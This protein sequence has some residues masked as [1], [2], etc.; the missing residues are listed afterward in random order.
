MNYRQVLLTLIV[1]TLCVGP[2]AAFDDTPNGEVGEF[3]S[4]TANGEIQAIAEDNGTVYVVGGDGNGD[5]IMRSHN[6]SGDVTL[7]S[8]S[9]LPATDVVVMDGVAYVSDKQG[10]LHIIDSG[11]VNSTNIA[12]NQIT[13]LATGGQY[14]Y[15]ITE[16]H[17]IQKIN[18]SGGVSEE[19][20]ASQ[21]WEPRS[22]SYTDNGLLVA[23]SNG[24][25]FHNLTT[26]V[27]SYEWTESGTTVN[28][29]Y[30]E[31]GNAYLVAQSGEL[32]EVDVSANTNT[33]VY[34]GSNSLGSIAVDGDHWYVT[35]GDGNVTI[36]NSSY[37]EEDSIDITSDEIQGLATANRSVVIGN[38]DSYAT[39]QRYGHIGY[40]VPINVTDTDNESV[41]NVTISDGVPYTSKKNV[42]DG[43]TL[44][45]PPETQNMTAKKDGYL[46]SSKNVTITSS[47]RTNGV[48]ITLESGGEISGKVYG[49]DVDGPLQ[50][51]TVTVDG[52]TRTVDGNFSFTVTDGEYYVNVD[53]PGYIPKNETV[54]I[55]GNNWSQ[56]ITLET[57]YVVSGVVENQAGNPVPS[58]VIESPVTTVSTDESGSFSIPVKEGKS[59]LSV[60]ADGYVTRSYV[61]ENVTSDRSGVNITVVSEVGGGGSTQNFSTIPLFGTQIPLPLIQFGAVFL[62]LSAL[63]VG[64]FLYYREPDEEFH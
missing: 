54:T 36:L 8:S 38:T 28:D 22:L 21:T 49:Q 63:A 24:Y 53:K 14:V 10:T 23:G 26:N 46:Q 42:S 50:N 61:V 48:S 3:W 57:G 62:L 13:G 30:A 47:S 17:K 43:E 11:S 2:V 51:V 58:A 5:G 16:Q 25:G 29:T 60:S 31:N 33:T 37:L 4:S 55:S 27:D 6:L 35:T 40:K 32:I 19:W 59:N 44:L 34:T 64:A 7:V 52:T 45:L 15:A 12:S 18:S 56:D 9:T 20:N 1:F 39:Y 41:S